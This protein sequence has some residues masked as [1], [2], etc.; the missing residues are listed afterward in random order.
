[1]KPKQMV[2]VGALLT[3]YLH[4]PGEEV[5]NKIGRHRHQHHSRS[6]SASDMLKNVPFIQVTVKLKF[7]LGS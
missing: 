2:N 5:N 3:Y 6:L 1:M 4:K 7:S